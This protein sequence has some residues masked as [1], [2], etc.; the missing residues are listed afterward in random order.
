MKILSELVSKKK[1]V[2][3]DV[4]SYNVEENNDK[5][6]RVNEYKNGEFNTDYQRSTKKAAFNLFNSILSTGAT[7]V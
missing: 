3:G 6:F 1:N 4:Y 5:D 7:R 2:F